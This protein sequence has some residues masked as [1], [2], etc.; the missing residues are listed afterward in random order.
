M[1]TKKCTQKEVFR[2]L[3]LSIFNN[4]IMYHIDM[5]V[6]LERIQHYENVLHKPVLILNLRVFVKKKKKNQNRMCQYM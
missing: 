4:N 1:D 6:K 3:G 5:L 2:L